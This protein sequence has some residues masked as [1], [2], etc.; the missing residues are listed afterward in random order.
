VNGTATIVMPICVRAVR[1]FWLGK[2][3]RVDGIDD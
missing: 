2:N 3:K 1:V